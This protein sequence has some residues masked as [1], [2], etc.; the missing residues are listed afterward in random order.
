MVSTLCASH[1]PLAAGR[2][3]MVA[4]LVRVPLAGGLALAGE[5][6][7]PHL[8]VHQR[9]WV[10]DSLSAAAQEMAAGAPRLGGAAPPAALPGGQ[11]AAGEGK[12]LHCGSRA[13]FLTDWDSLPCSMRKRSMA[14]GYAMQSSSRNA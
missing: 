8:D 13:A 9:L 4:L 10:L 5:V 12:W 11:P 6:Y 1:R 3:A 2:R 14:H 7:S